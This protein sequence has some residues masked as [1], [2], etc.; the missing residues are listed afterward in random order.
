MLRRLVSELSSSLFAAFGA[1][2]EAVDVVVVVVA[3]AVVVAVVVV[4]DAAE[5]VIVVH[6]RLAL[7]SEV[8]KM[9][10]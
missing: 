8:L 6:L 10:F 4:V 1:D 3:V 5:I 7:K 9:Q 2:D